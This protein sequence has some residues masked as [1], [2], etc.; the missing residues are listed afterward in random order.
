MGYSE[1]DCCL[2]KQ[3]YVQLRKPSK[4]EVKKMI[5]TTYKDRCEN[6][7]KVDR[8]VEYMWEKEEED[9]NE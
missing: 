9:T 1:V 6:C 5:L 4:K 7:H 8:L 3:C 2:C